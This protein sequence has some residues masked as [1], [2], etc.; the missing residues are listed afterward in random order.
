MIKKLNLLLLF[1]LLI[2]FAFSY[3]IK[4][5]DKDFYPSKQYLANIGRAPFSLTSNEFVKKRCTSF[6]RSLKGNKNIHISYLFNTFGNNE[7][8]LNRLLKNPNLK[9]LQVHLLN[10]P[11]HRNRERMKRFYGN[12]EFLEPISV[13]QWQEILTS[14]NLNWKRK[15]IEYTQ[16]LVEMIELRKRNDTACM[17]SPDLESNLTDRKAINT[18]I[19][20]TREIFPSC[21]IVW[22]PLS[23]V[24]SNRGYNANYIE[25]HGVNPLV[26]P[27]C[28]V[29]PDGAD[30]Q[31][32]YR[33]TL[34]WAGDESDIKNFI[35]FGRPLQ[36]YVETYGNRCRVVF[37]WTFED[38]MIFT[39]SFIDPRKRTWRS[40]G[41]RI[42]QDLGKEIKRYTKQALQE[43]EKIVW[44]KAD[45]KSLRKCKQV[46]SPRDEIFGIDGFKVGFTYKQSEFP[47]RG[48]A[49][50]LPSFDRAKK[51]EIFFRGKSRIAL[52][53]NGLYKDRSRTVW[54]SSVPPSSL[55]LKGVIKV[56]GGEVCYRLPNPRL[57]L[58]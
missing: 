24:S 43:P 14:N 38:N 18:L 52:E 34:A 35:N 48:I 15:F 53:Y 46:I 47:D 19:S 9:T 32:P 51:V 17:I 11:G 12:Y 13:K 36:Q 26:F 44:S 4:N 54:R 41:N 45:D 21:E 16:P 20:W 5:P 3:S 50:L 31:F 57:R 49:L 8:C 58:D 2:L 56:N 23:R 40:V 1:I 33:K 39:R 25:Q 55:A 29:N 37:L 30:I 27:P 7:A 42:D 10:S 6:L 28:V 22:N